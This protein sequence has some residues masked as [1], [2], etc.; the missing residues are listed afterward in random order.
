MILNFY[1][2]LNYTILCI[3]FFTLFTLHESVTTSYSNVSDILSRL[4]MNDF[5]IN[6][7]YVLW[8]SFWYLPTFLVLSFSVVLV[9]S[10]KNAVGYTWLVVGLVLVA[11]SLHYQN[12][13]LYNY[14]VDNCGSNFNTLL[15][16]SV[17]KFH[18]ALF[19][20][21]LFH[22]LASLQLLLL[23]NQRRYAL[24]LNL[25]CNTSTSNSLIL[26]IVFTLFLGSWWALQEGSWGGWWNWD[27]S[28]V[29][30]LFVMLYYLYTIHK[31]QKIN[32]YPVLTFYLKN[33]SNL[34]LLTYVFIQLNFDLVSHNF[35]TKVDQFIDTSQN[36]IILTISLLILVVLLIGH[37]LR[38]LIEAVTTSSCS[39]TYTRRPVLV[40][41]MSLIL[42]LTFI[43]LSSFSLLINDF[44]WKLLSVNIFNSTK[45]TY[46]YTSLLVTIILVRLWDS[47]LFVV[48]LPVF[49]AYISKEV[50]ILLV[51]PAVTRVNLFHL[52]LV[53]LLLVMLS[54]SNQSVSFWEILYENASHVEAQVVYDMSAPF[55]SL[56]NFM[57]ECLFN[58]LTNNKTLESVW[59]FTWTASSNENHSFSHSITPNLLTQSLYSGN[60]L[61]NY[62]INV[63]D[64]CITTTNLMLAAA[65]VA[66]RYLLKTH[67]LITS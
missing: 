24:N 55:V 62:M 54:E 44:L 7:Y 26:V 6:S 21:T 60:G 4:F 45:F 48:L 29:F 12:L 56:N 42:V 13:N 53:S 22:L 14:T 19:Y 61:S 18:P 27:P 25:S 64:F 36:F 50:L 17:N 43:L 52:S 35:G 15:S 41:H 20:I 28:E 31:S 8:T 67:K 46:F 38:G 32:S 23:N 34:V 49:A 16:N 59:N 33:L 51:V 11:V 57:T 58:V 10:S 9:N 40:W 39:V 47:R 65:L 30:G 2:A 37:L 3:Y 63:L 5:F 66:L 1:I